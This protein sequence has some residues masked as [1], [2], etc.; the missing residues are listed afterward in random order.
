MTECGRHGSQPRVFT[1]PASAPFLPTLID[2]LMDG[3][4]GARL[5]AGR[6]SAGAGRRDALPADPA[7]LP[8][9]A[10]HVPRRRSKATPRSCRASCRSATSTR[11]RSR[12]REAAT[13]DIAAEALDL[14]EALGGSS[15]QCCWPQ[16]ILQWA[17]APDHA[18]RQ[19]QA[20]LVASSPAAA[21]AL[22]DD[23]ARLMDDMTTRQVP[24]DAARRPGAGRARPTTGSSRSSS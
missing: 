21:L 18:R 2:A 12:S 4:A 1:I 22:A 7:R 6:R 5:P 14:P 13:G 10:R 16:L 24:W 17:A 23:L 11:T 15:A 9:G 3:P 19:G 20:P 8:A